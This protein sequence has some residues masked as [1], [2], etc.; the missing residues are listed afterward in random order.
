ME[1][2]AYSKPGT[3]WLRPLSPTAT[4]KLASSLTMTQRSWKSRL[5][6]T[7]TLLQ[8]ARLAGANF[9]LSDY[10]SVNDD[11]PTLRDSEKR[12]TLLAKSMVNCNEFL[13]HILSE[14]HQGLLSEK[15]G[16]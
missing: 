15:N 11:L 13:E 12:S 2:T 9:T 8:L 5:R 3:T 6:L 16:W 14:F 4:G 1:C 10:V 7:T